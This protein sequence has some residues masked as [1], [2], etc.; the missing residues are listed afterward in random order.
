[1]ASGFF[2]IFDDVASLM[3]DVAVMGKAAAKKTAGVLGDDLAVNA[4]KAA[5]FPPSR[6]LPVLWAITKG[7]FLNKLILLPLAFLLSAFAPWAITPI[8]MLGGVYLAYEGAEKIVE[9]W[10]GRPHEDEEDARKGEGVDDPVEAERKKVRSAIVT[11]FILSIEIVIIALGSVEHQPLAVQI[12]VVTAVA[13][14]ATVGVYGLVAL[15]VRLD[16]MGYA[17]LRLDDG[18][19]K[20]PAVVIGRFLIASLPRIVRGLSVVGTFAMLLVAGGIFV[21]HL[22]FLHSLL[23]PLPGIVADL[24]VGFLLGMLAVAAVE[25]WRRLRRA[26]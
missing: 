1:M 5:G 4:D 12:P 16:D 26:F 14:L 9:W 20:G 11:D 6:E 24:L 22:L 15:I 18:D 7:S 17:I 2:A 13:F 3:D 8:L 23:M 21:H 10:T 25:G 19:G